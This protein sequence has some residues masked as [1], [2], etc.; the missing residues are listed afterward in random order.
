MDTRS[1]V[2]F[3]D[4]VDAKSPSFADNWSRGMYE[5]ALESSEHMATLDTIRFAHWP[6]GRKIN[7]PKYRLKYQ[8]FFFMKLVE[9][10]FFF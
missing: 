6:I 8:I 9:F 2:G 1:A 7:V 5:V 10:V 3:T 4:S